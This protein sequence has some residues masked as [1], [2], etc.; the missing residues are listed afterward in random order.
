MSERHELILIIDYGSQYTQLIA[1]RIREQKVFCR[2]VPPEWLTTELLTKEHPKGLILSGGPNSVYQPNAPLPQREIFEQGVPTLGICYGMQAMA[3]QLGGTVE[4]AEKR[5]Y[6]KAPVR[7][8]AADGLFESVKPESISWMSH[9]DSV[10]KAPAGFTVSA[11]TDNTVSAAIADPKRRLYGLQFHPEVAHTEEGQ[12]ILK[13]FLFKICGCKGEWTMTSFIE[14]ACERIRQQVGKGHVILG[15]SGG[16]DSSVAAALLNKAIGKQLTCIFVDHGLGR[17]GERTQIEETFGAHFKTDL[18]VIDAADRFLAKLHGVTD[19]ETKR[20]RIGEEFVRVFE[21]EAKK[22]PGVAFLAQGTLYP[23]VIESVSAWGGP[24]ATIKTHHNVGGLPEKMHLKLVEPLRDL[25]KDEVRELGKLLGLPDDMVYR[26]PFPGPGLAVRILGEVTRE[27]LRIVREA[28]VRVD[29]EIR[30][31]GLYRK[32]WQSF[33]VL[34]PVKTVGV[35]GDER[36]Y[37]YVIAIRAV[38][39]LDAMTADWAKLPA[40]VLER[41][42]NRIINEVKG[43]NRV[44]YDISSKPPATIEWE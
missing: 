9:G 18:H 30:R 1:R 4:R 31:A 11:K 21:D 3:H 39:S 36:T 19:P 24:S 34:L 17:S 22:I 25:F 15:L 41:I 32:L 13:N 40:D 26:Q 16:V 12:K 42:S 5:E 27:R 33:A 28:D 35:M 7:V 37:E 23:D 29:E 20:K 6:G 10:V 2:I 8:L 43:V 44:V 14:E 38:T